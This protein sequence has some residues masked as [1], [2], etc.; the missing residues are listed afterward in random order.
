MEMTTLIYRINKLI[1]LNRL[2]ISSGIDTA[3]PPEAL[4]A[5]EDET[6]QLE[7]VY[8]EVKKHLEQ[9]V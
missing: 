7:T 5:L 2:L 1:L 3:N 6:E 4:Y 8:L 9:Y